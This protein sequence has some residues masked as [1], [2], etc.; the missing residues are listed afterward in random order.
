M[1][2]RTLVE[3]NHDYCPRDDDAS[4]LAWAKAM[5]LYM[6]SGMKEHLPRGVTFKQIRHHTDPDPMFNKPGDRT[7]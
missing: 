3:L 4:L 2:N 6:G 5:R 1:S 7:P